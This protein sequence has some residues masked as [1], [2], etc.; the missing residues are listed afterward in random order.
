MTSLAGL[1]LCGGRSQ[2]MGADKALIQL[3]GTPLVLRVAE[4]VARVADPIM[5]APGNPGRL[6]LK[7]LPYSEVPDEVADAGPLA[8]IVAGMAVSPHPLM[9]V[10]AVDLPFANPELLR[11]LAELHEDED[12]VV[13]V[14]SSGPEPLHA[15]YSREALPSLRAA[16]A[17][18]R[19]AL[20]SVLD[21]LRARFVDERQWR[22]LDPSGRFA[23]N[24]NRAE[25]LSLLG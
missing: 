2:R 21:G 10:V 23:V 18:R 8:G 17:E 13:P 7:G 20:H 1:I 22:D 11:R 9:A 4:R 5:L 6:G 16:L 25:D 12:A 24:L 15:V 14:S 19:L 3:D